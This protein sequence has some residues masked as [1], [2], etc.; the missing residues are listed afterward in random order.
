MD[1]GVQFPP[2]KE[3]GDVDTGTAVH[4]NAAEKV[5]EMD[6][7]TDV[8]NVFDS[9][10]AHS[11]SAFATQAL[12]SFNSINALVNENIFLIKISMTICLL[13]LFQICLMA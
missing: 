3:S 8:N 7:V 1:K 13:V 11:S 12:P 6:N 5:H 9:R 10:I 4:A 2:L